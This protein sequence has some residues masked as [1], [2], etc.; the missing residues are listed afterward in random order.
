MRTSESNFEGSVQLGLKSKTTVI[1]A[2]IFTSYA[3][4]LFPL[5]Y[6]KKLVLL[7]MDAVPMRIWHSQSS[8]LPRLTAISASGSPPY[9]FYDSLVERHAYNEDGGS[10]INPSESVG[11]VNFPELKHLYFTRMDFNRNSRGSEDSLVNSL[12]L[13]LNSRQKTMIPIT[14]ILLAECE[15]LTRDIISWLE[16]EVVQV[17][18]DI[19][20]D[21][22]ES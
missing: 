8:R 10:L 14:A 9:G 4:E 22:A 20:D 6:V 7:N 1:S 13:I 15:G 19:V 12:Q 5:D 18:S 11:V 3:L 17:K 2:T 21:D 16:D